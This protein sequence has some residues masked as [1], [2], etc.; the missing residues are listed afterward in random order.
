MSGKE[1]D[2]SCQL[3]KVRIHVKRVIS[4]I[5]KFRMLQVIVPV[6]QIDL[7]DEITMIVCA[8]INLNKSIIHKIHIAANKYIYREI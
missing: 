4:Q 3:S 5:R 7:L 6:T 8:I 2:T 1:V